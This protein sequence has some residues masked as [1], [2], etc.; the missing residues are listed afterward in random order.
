M[1]T[2]VD[3]VQI[4]HAAFVAQLLAQGEHH[5]AQIGIDGF[6]PIGLLGERAAD[7]NRAQRGH[8]MIDEFHGRSAVGGVHIHLRGIQR[9]QRRTHAL[10][11]VGR[12]FDA[13]AV[14]LQL[15]ILPRL[16]V[17]SVDAVDGFAQVVGLLA[18]RGFLR[19]QAFQP[20]IHGGQ[21]IPRLAVGGQFGFVSG[22]PVQKLA[23]P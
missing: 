6:K 8:R 17:D 4:L 10:G 11:D 7:A 21:R 19:A 22:H 3:L 15:L 18:G 13:F 16:R 23:L 14:R 1:D 2:A 9:A 12:V 20:L 5:V